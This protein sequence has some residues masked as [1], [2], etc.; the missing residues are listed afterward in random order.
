M[1]SS[2]LLGSHMFNQ[3]IIFLFQKK[4]S[5]IQPQSICATNLLIKATL[6]KMGYRVESTNKLSQFLQHFKLVKLQVLFPP[7]MLLNV[8]KPGYF[9]KKSACGTLKY[10]LKKFNF[11]ISLIS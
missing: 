9:Q 5:S 7:Y 6:G 4:H 10:T 1:D 11:V 2:I 8:Q 3:H